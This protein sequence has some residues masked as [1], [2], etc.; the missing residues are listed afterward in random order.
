MMKEKRSRCDINIPKVMQI[1]VYIYQTNKKSFVA[2]QPKNK[3]NL[4]SADQL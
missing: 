2:V 1:S 4:E 3:C